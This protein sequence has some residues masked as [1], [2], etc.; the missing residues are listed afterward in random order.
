MDEHVHD[1]WRRFGRTRV[2]RPTWPGSAELTPGQLGSSVFM[3]V[4]N[5][6]VEHE[7]RTGNYA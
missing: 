3:Y 1:G 2:L 7:V 6:K 5:V 4:E